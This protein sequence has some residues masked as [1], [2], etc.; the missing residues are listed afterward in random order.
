MLNYQ[1]PN[2]NTH[3]T[4][5]FE[6]NWSIDQLARLNPC[7]FSTEENPSYLTDIDKE[8]CPFEKVNKDFFNRSFII[9]SPE[10][11]TTPVDMFQEHFSLRRAGSMEL[12]SPS[13]GIRSKATPSKLG[14]GS[15]GRSFLRDISNHEKPHTPLN[16]SRLKQKKK[17]FE[18]E[19]FS[20]DENAMSFIC[21]TS[22]SSTTDTRLRS[23]FIVENEVHESLQFLSPIVGQYDESDGG[24]GG[25]SSSRNAHPD[26][27]P[28]ICEESSSN[29][30]ITLDAD[31]TFADELSADSGCNSQSLEQKPFRSLFF[32]KT[33][34]PSHI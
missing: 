24:V 32:T 4:S 12:N 20:H 28:V 17:L 30:M 29:S 21:D 18:D 26:T 10:Y 9:P 33:S 34:T 23:S 22:M 16:N 25:M 13:A 11:G 27:L 19:M 8:N 15:F 31:S 14:D 2:N 3:N 5:G 1:T 6:F 7:D